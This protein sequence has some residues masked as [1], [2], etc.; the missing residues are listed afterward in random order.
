MGGSRNVVSD[1]LVQQANVLISAVER[2]SPS[3]TTATGLPRYGVV[4]NTSTWLKRRAV[5]ARAGYRR[6]HGRGPAAAPAR[7][8]GTQTPRDPRRPSTQMFG[9]VSKPWSARLDR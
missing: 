6:P 2:S 7:A 8:D 5:N 9:S 3:S 1:R 4:V